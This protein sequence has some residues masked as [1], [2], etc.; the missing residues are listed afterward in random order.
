MCYLSVE[1]VDSVITCVCSKTSASLNIEEVAP[2]SFLIM[3]NK[4][5]D[6]IASLISGAKGLL[7]LFCSWNFLTQRR[8][9]APDAPNNKKLVD[10]VRRLEDG[11]FK[12][13][14]TMVCFFYS[15]FSCN[16]FP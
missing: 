16:H 3:S 2:L 12:S 7:F 15:A 8:Q 13:A 6:E 4:M 5:I 9:Q 14:T 1:L 11:L 10:I